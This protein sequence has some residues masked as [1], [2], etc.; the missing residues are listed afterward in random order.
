MTF[1]KS[2]SIF[3]YFFLVLHCSSANHRA[4]ATYEPSSSN[5]SESM[6]EESSKQSMKKVSSPQKNNPNSTTEKSSSPRKMI[7]NVNVTMQAKDQESKVKEVIQLAESFEGYALSYSSNGN[8]SLKIPAEHLKV[9]LEKLKAISEQYSEELLAKDVTEEYLDV[10]MRLENAK[11]MRVRLLELLKLAKSLEE[12][13]KVEAEINKV[14]E[15][16]ERI[17]GRLKF[18]NTNISLSTINVRI[19][20]KYEPY[21]ETEYKPGPLGYP[22]YYAYLGVNYAVK[23]VIWLFVQE[24][25]IEESNKNPI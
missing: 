22:F 20:R 5:R 17:E 7:Y 12:I 8:L 3:L 18:L 1:F 23:K 2:I 6:D 16:I 11:K 9:F 24:E 14:S 10:E 13:M 4:E 19:L 25:D 15:N 21:R